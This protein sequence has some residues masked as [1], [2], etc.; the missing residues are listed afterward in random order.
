MHPTLLIWLGL[1]VLLYLFLR[2]NASGAIGRAFNMQSPMKAVMAAYRAGDYE[3][4]LQKAERLKNGALKTHPYCFMRGALLHRLGRFSEAEDSLREAT[5]LEADS[6]QTALAY[7]VLATVMMD[8]G[9]FSEAITFYGNAGHLWPEYGSSRRG[10]AEAW[11]RQGCESPVALEHARQAVEIDKR[12]AG[13][14]SEVLD[15][16]LGEDLAVLAWA[17]AANSGDI[18]EVESLAA[19]SSRL[20][21]SNSKPILGQINYHA[22]RAYEAIRIS[23]KA[24]DHF[25]RAMQADPKGIFGRLAGEMLSKMS[26]ER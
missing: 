22:G 19:E 23:N 13:M 9:R 3:T 11:L 1:F 6:R 8:A 21:G 15:T 24:G 7:D 26:P 14:T 12:A 4:A 5:A 20:C 25:R 2:S 16:R 18:S 17:V 10:I